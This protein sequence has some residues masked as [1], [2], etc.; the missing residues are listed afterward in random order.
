MARPGWRSA[1]FREFV[2]KVHGRCNLACDY[3]YMYELADQSWR[4]RPGAMSTKILDQTARRIGEHAAAHALPEVCVVFHGGEPLLAGPQFIDEASATL[5]AAM[6]SDTTLRLSVQTNA[7][8]LNEE[9]LRVFDRHDIDVG[10][11]LDGNRHANDRHRRHANGRSSYEEVVRGLR[12]LNRPSYRRLFSGL[13]CTIDVDNDPVD[14]YEAL[15]E[16]EPPTMDFML[17][18]ANWNEPPPHWRDDPEH[19]PYGD[20]LVAIFERW[21]SAPSEETVVRTLRAVVDEM[22]GGRSNDE[23]IGLAAIRLIEVETSAT[24]EQV[25]SLKSAFEGATATGFDIFSH[26]FDDALKHPGVVARQAGLDALS[27]T[28]MGCRVRDICGGGHYVHRY[29]AGSGFRHPSVYCADLYRLVTYIAQRIAADL[30]DAAEVV[31]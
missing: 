12:L 4:T 5:R 24:V 19:T 18:H 20:W 1:P 16:F 15:L 29:R 27:D 11:S 30:R 23:V 22:L 31:R 6:P 8:L 25:C 2:L 14:S 21:Y 26:S 9:F 10:V 3:C 13:L 7:V 28:C 17:P